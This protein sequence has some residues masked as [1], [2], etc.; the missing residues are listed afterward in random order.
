[1]KKG[2]CYPIVLFKLGNFVN[3]V[4]FFARFS[5]TLISALHSNMQLLKKLHKNQLKKQGKHSHV[6]ITCNIFFYDLY[7][8]INSPIKTIKNRRVKQFNHYIVNKKNLFV[9]WICFHQSCR[10]NFASCF[11]VQ[12]R[13]RFDIGP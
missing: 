11:Y 5:A 4:L 13:C 8:L 6:K 10:K 12:C 1:M 3:V 7:I 9:R 2:K